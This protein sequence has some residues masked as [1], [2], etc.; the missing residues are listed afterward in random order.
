MPNLTINGMSMSVPEGTTILSAATQAGIEIPHY[1]Y[2]PRLSIA[3]N[4]RMCLV[5]VEKFPKLQTACS[6]VVTEGMVVRTDTEK[7]YKA[8]TGVLE[9]MLIHHPIDCPICD[10]AGECGL[11]IYYMKYGL[12]KSRYPLQDKVHKKKVQDI[13]GQIVLDAERCILC[14]RCVRFLDEVTGTRELNFFQRGDH[15]EISIFPGYPLK[16]NYTGN[17]ADICPVGALTSKDFRFKC[18]VWFLKGFDSICT[19]CAAG[20]NVEA[21]FKGDILYRYKPRANDAV[22]RTWMCDFGRLEYKKANEGRLLT[23]FVREGGAQKVV[24][25]GGLIAEVALALSRAAE[26]DGGGAVGVIASPQSS[27]EEL[28]LLRRIAFELLGTKNLCFTPR[29]PG[30]GFSDGFLILADKNPN[31][32]GARLL[33]IPDDAAFDA[34]ACRITAGEIRALLVAGNALGAFTE[35]ETAELL[36]KVPFVAQVGTSD[37]PVSRA[38]HAVLPSASFAE[39]GGTFT[40][41]AGRVQRFRAGFPPRGKSRN[42]I[43]ILT[44]LANRLGADWTFEDERSVFRELSQTEAPFGGMTYESIGSLGQEVRE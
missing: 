14:S 23:P 15:S 43:G 36:S 4:C 26:R 5:D 9:L 37:G 44:E 38:A 20:C 41:H 3:G 21:H 35:G 34:L 24:S 16:N 39:R 22:N 12:H 29:V 32:R 25:W 27:N 28:Y 33:G 42:P 18:R 6:T 11:Q 31:S 17:L 30:D 40:N 19:G 8:V 13:G 7:V 1:C 2:H 10:Q